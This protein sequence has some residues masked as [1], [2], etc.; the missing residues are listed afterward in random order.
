VPGQRDGE[1]LLRQRPQL[2]G[3]EGK[4]QAL[5]C[6]TQKS[7]R[8]L[9]VLSSDADSSSRPSGEKA[10]AR[11]APAWPFSTE[12]R[13]SLQRKASRAQRQRGK[14]LASAPRRRPSLAGTHAVGSHRRTVRSLEP[15]AMSPFA[16]EKA[17][18]CTLAC[19]GACAVARGLSVACEGA[20]ACIMTRCAQQAAPRCWTRRVSSE[21]VGAQRGL[22]VPNQHVSV[23]PRRHQLT[24]VGVEREAGHAAAVA[25]ERALQARL[26]ASKLQAGKQRQRLRRAAR[27]GAMQRRSSS[28]PHL[29]R[30]PYGA[31]PSSRSGSGASA[32]CLF[33]GTNG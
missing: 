29:Q 20:R 31:W 5:Q 30:Q 11:T 14:L 26:G 25:A 7:R 2:Q 23:Q 10:T 13:P 19:A 21:A 9:T 16:S 3:S 24:H 12:E 1:A 27:A 33:E 4:R 6:T 17:T 18:E 32:V 22:E 28:A 8:T 15:E